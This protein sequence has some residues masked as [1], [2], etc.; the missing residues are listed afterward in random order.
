MAS[1]R[2]VAQALSRPTMASVFQS[3]CGSVI[4]AGF[5]ASRGRGPLAL[6]HQAYPLRPALILSR[7]S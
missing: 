7:Q 3:L 6:P 1:C 4:I 5:V 2:M